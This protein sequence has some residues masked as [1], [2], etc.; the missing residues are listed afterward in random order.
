MRWIAIVALVGSGLACGNKKSETGSSLCAAGT[1]EKR[2]ESPAG[3]AVWCERDGSVKHGPWREFAPD[4]SLRVEGQYADGKMDGVWTH[5]HPSPKDTGDSATAKPASSTAAAPT[6]RE[7][8][9]SYRAGRKLG[10]WTRWHANGV[11]AREATHDPATTTVPWTT[12][13]EDGS[14]WATGTIVELRDQGEYT[15]WHPNGK[16]GAKGVYEKGEKV[17]E[18]QYWD[19]DGN[20]S[21]TPQGD[22]GQ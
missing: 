5:Y 4:S 9:G 20:P 13:R 2:S 1:A 11:K 12:W 14:K 21:T 16:L 19:L 22:V 18:W 7:R 15:E 17:G 10:V 6:A 8:Q 3:A